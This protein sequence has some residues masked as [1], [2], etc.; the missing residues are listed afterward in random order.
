MQIVIK[1]VAYYK[2]DLKL[3]WNFPELFLT[4]ISQNKATLACPPGF[5]GVPDNDQADTLIKQKSPKP[6]IDLRP[7]YIAT[8]PTS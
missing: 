7:G 5:R 3:I 2:F 1:A 4:L 6:H 8:R